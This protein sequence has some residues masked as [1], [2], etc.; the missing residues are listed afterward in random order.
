MQPHGSRAAGPHSTSVVAVTIGSAAHVGPPQEAMRC[1]W[2]R[3]RRLHSVAS[4]HRCG[5]EQEELGRGA[6]LKG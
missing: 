4:P 3:P 1:A 6:A 2:T 5:M